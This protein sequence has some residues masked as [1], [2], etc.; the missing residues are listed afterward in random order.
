MYN[1]ITGKLWNRKLC[2]ELLGD[3]RSVQRETSSRREKA[4]WAE[5]LV[6][7][8]QHEE[9]NGTV[10]YSYSRCKDLKESNWSCVFGL[11]QSSLVDTMGKRSRGKQYIKSQ[12]SDW[13]FGRE[14]CIHASI[15]QMGY[16]RHSP[17][18][19]ANAPAQPWGTFH[20]SVWK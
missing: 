18:G 3:R 8:H 9:G 15:L 20:E 13:R 10:L 6:R 1:K 14:W 2:P 5:K 7:A 11:K 4:L 12:G 19:R 17:E 16:W